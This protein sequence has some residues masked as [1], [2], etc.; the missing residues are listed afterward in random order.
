MEVL[1]VVIQVV[2]PVDDLTKT[3]LNLDLVT[4]FRQDV[5]V[6]DLVQVVDDSIR[7]HPHVNRYRVKF[8]NLTK[9]LYLLCFIILLGRFMVWRLSQ[10]TSVRLPLKTSAMTLSC[11]GKKTSSS[12]RGCCQ[13]C[14]LSSSSAPSWGR[15]YSQRLSLSSSGSVSATV[16]CSGCCCRLRQYLVGVVSALEGILRPLLLLFSSSQICSGHCR[17]LATALSM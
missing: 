15:F 1:E 2:H 8:P 10:Y 11:L 3:H 7:V 16:I 17:P 9:C 14:R 4:H 6:E 12:R 5:L 13:C